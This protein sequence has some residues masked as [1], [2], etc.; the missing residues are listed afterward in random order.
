MTKRGGCNM[1]HGKFKYLI[2]GLVILQLVF[3]EE[4]RINENDQSTEKHFN[5]TSIIFR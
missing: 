4:R 5:L 3:F 1:K 2:L